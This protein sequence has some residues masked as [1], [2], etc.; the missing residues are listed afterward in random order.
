MVHRPASPLRC[1]AGAFGLVLTVSLGACGS[2]PAAIDPA[3][4]PN[5]A[6][7]RALPDLI[8]REEIVRRGTTTQTAFALVR[9]LRPSWLLARGQTSFTIPESAYAV[10]YVDGVRRGGLA[11][12]YQ[13]A[14]N[15]IERMEFL[16]TAD[17]TTRWGTGHQAG[18]INVVMR[19]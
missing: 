14:P 12:L 8:V 10:V 7:E 15:Q 16:G 5:A 11:V 2:S 17:A 19:R 6:R 3:S 4:P 1:S 18:A 13:I 9:R